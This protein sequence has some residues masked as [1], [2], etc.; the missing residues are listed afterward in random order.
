MPLRL[1]AQVTLSVLL[2]ATVLMG[3]SAAS[4]D[5]DHADHVHF[6]ITS[7]ANGDWSD[8][9]TWEPARVPQHDD[10]VLI[11]RG[12][13]VRY[14]V[15][16]RDVI[17]LLQIVGTL[18]FADD[19]DT[20]LNVGLLKVQNSDTCSE[21]GFACDFHD[22]NAAGEPIGLPGGPL[23][24]LLVGTPEKPI[25]AEH[26][27]RIRLHYLDGMNKD[28]APAIAC[29]SARM[30]IHGAPLDRTWVKLGA[31][32]EPGGSEITLAEEVSGWR[33]GDEVI[34]TASSRGSRGRTFRNAPDSVNTEKRQIAKVA[35]LR[36]TLDRPV[37]KAHRGSGEFRSEIAN[38]SRNV[39][40]ESADPAGV[41]GHTVFHRF[42]QGGISYAR[43]AHLGKE[44]VL[45][46]YSIHFHVVGDTMRGSSVQGVAIVDSHNRWVTIHGTQYLV[47]RDCVGY[48][49]V[50]HGFFL[51]DGTEVYNLLDRNLGVHAFKGRPLPKQVL[52]FDPNDGA[53]FWWGNGRNTLT[54]NV[55]CENDEYGYRFDIQRT[56]RFD[57]NLPI[58]QPD[59]EI[60][61]VD[62]RTIPI[63]RFEDNEAHSEGFYGMLVAANGNSQPDNA[64]RDENMLA[65][66]KRIDWTGPDTR[67]PHTI[68]NLSIWGSHYAFRPHS[69]AMFM[70]NI[71]IHDAAYG[72]YRP[73]FENQV[74]RNLH[75]SSVGAEP[76]NRGMDD[77]SAQTGQITVDGLTFTS[78]YGNDSTPLIQ[79][80]DVNISGNAETHLR[81]VTV[82][83]AERFEN[84]WP[85]INRGVGPRVAPL[86]KGV[87]IYIHD[88]F[89]PGRHAKVVSNAAEDLLAD[90]NK[91]TSQPPLTGSEARVAEVKDA[92][93][94]ELLDRVDDVPPATIITSVG[95]HAGH[96][97]VRGVSHDNGEISSINVNGRQATIISRSAGVVDWRIELDTP[98]DGRLIAFARDAAGNVEQTQ[99]KTTM[100]KALLSGVAA[101][102][103]N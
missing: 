75:I 5:D 59:G 96:V 69:P 70:E 30:E 83:R 9:K 49:S 103:S 66:I 28:D 43:F 14:D 16:S 64:I 86:T 32:V 58:L 61:T 73:A 45:G 35:G 24:A 99:H 67:H 78:G 2:A 92:A 60:T 3:C 102:L 46:R 15:Q 88:Y 38:L 41:R 51:E 89:G 85:L 20:E 81:N 79:I 100:R 87:P 13:S 74:Y 76:F 22:V 29:C 65:Q 95:L 27:A 40:I 4:A 34:V 94:P 36:I 8:A 12:T 11:R 37:D 42:S 62:V 56:S 72:I 93:W 33:V 10:R 50:G 91:Y 52:S 101:N 7:V 17:R 80:S 54:R 31:D 57:P 98:A 77:A 68:R 47:V 39:I 82:N 26:T 44:G 48:G 53:A 84:R 1:S 63:W 71:R 97:V 23:P 18:R 90:G 21:S 25:P 55:S 19:R 6:S